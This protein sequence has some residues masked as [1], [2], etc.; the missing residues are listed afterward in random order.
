VTRGETQ[1]DAK[2][3]ARIT[4]GH[5]GQEAVAVFSRWPPS[6]RKLLAYK[7]LGLRERQAPS[8]NGEARPQ[9]RVISALF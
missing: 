6:G 2:N 7:F 1:D 4:R 3:N 5:L 9:D 8:R